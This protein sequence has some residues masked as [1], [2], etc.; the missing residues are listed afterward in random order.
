[1][2]RKR[3]KKQNANSNNT[4]HNF[5]K[6]KPRSKNQRDL[7]KSIYENDIV[8]CTGP[9]GTGKTCVSVGA[10]VYFLMTNKLEKIVV[11][12]P[13]VEAGQ[14][15]NKGRSAVGYLPGDINEK[16]SPFLRPLYDEFNKF[17]GP[18]KLNELQTSKVIEICP[19]EFMR[20][21]TFEN[22]F[23]ICD[24]AQNASEEQLEMLL[25]R[26]GNGSK[27]VISG[28][29]EQTDLCR[30][31]SGGL[32]NFCL[33]LDKINGIGIIELDINDVNRHPLVSKIIEI[34]RK[35]KEPVK[36]DFSRY[37]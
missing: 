12:R 19:L 26:L 13:L 17:I 7:L 16:M 24:E 36:N 35:K 18:Q 6:I 21:R 14:S 37:S 29:T 31:V 22:T 5:Q 2:T 4:N 25:T 23:I 20:G 32:S 8:F 30:D 34:R 28:D 11:T 15:Q 10:A 1:M 3:T 33:D 27:M 9:A